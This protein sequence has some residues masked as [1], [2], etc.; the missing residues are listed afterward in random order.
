MAQLGPAHGGRAHGKVVLTDFWTYTC[1]NWLRT[2]RL[3]SRV[4]E[5]YGEH[6]L[7]VVGVHSP[8]SR[9]STNAGNVREA[10]RDCRSRIR[11][12]S[13]R[14]RRSGTRSATTMAGRLHRP[15]P[16]GGSGTISSA[17]GRYDECER[18][19]QRCCASADADDPGDDLVSVVPAGIE[20]QADWTTLESP[21][22]YLGY[23][24]AHNF[25]LSG[26]A[27]LDE[28]R[29]LCPAGVARAEPVGPLGTGRPREGERAE[30]GRRADR[31]SLPCPRRPPRLAPT[32]RGA[33]VPF[34]RARR[35]RAS[36]RRPWLDVDAQGHGP[37]PSSGS[38]S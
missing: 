20:A 27:G 36:G 23:E 9:S 7:L 12:R 8:S 34:P 31:V 10:A 22:S 38:T 32:T 30:R 37:S 5:R 16:K 26:D 14:L 24:Q 3:R 4:G 35:R 6:G 19:I 21:E 25:G 28:A 29:T 33:A 17:E 15:T 13:T 1:I 2:A 18:I 11:S